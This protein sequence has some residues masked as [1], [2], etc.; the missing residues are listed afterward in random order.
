[1]DMDP[2]ELGHPRH[3]SHDVDGHDAKRFSGKNPGL[4]WRVWSDLV[5][6]E[7]A[8]QAMVRWIGVGPDSGHGQ[9][10]I[11]LM[12]HP[13][14]YTCGPRSRDV[15]Q[16]HSPGLKMRESGMLHSDVLALDVQQNHARVMAGY[17]SACRVGLEDL[18]QNHPRED[19]KNAP[20][21]MTS[22]GG[23]VTFHDPGQ[24]LVYV[25]V[26]LRQRQLSVHDFVQML[27][28]WAGQALAALGLQSALVPEHPGIWICDTGGV[29]EN[30][31]NLGHVT[32][33]LMHDEKRDGLSPGG[34]REGALRKVGS[35][36]IHVQAGVSY[37]GMTLNLST[38]LQA[39]TKIQP[40]GLSSNVMANLPPHI[41]WDDMDHAL[42]HTCPF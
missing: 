35:L 11:W 23:Q 8:V 15:Y 24:R 29:T 42:Y 21:V 27:Q 17:T 9:E 26:S 19:I 37:H 5:D 25:M 30:Y 33:K 38:D 16:A 6:Y 3:T 36:G 1:M 7:N 13:P 34:S 31:Q 40:C 32:S 20:W 10:A 28:Q 22:R 18:D 14:V 39:F 2:E 12:R 4:M 41:S